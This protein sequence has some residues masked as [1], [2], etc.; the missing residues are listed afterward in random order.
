V[1]AND[2]ASPPVLARARH[3]V[4]TRSRFPLTYPSVQHNVIR[5]VTLDL[6]SVIEVSSP[7]TMCASA[8]RRAEAR[9]HRVATNRLERKLPMGQLTSPLDSSDQQESCQKPWESWVTTVRYVVIRTVPR[10]I[11]ALL[12]WWDKSH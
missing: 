2:Q 3:V 11:P 12:W 1:T 5:W 6:H 7:S 9:L 4:W 8:G 10:V